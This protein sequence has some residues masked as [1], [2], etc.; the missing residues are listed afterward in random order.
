MPP[1][2]KSKPPPPRTINSSSSKKAEL[3]QLRFTGEI[4]TNELAQYK[5]A[6]DT[7][8]SKLK[9]AYAGIGQQNTALT[10]LVSQRDDLLKKLN[11]S[12]KDRNDVVAKYNDL[13][14]QIQKQQ[15]AQK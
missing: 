6:V 13:A 14:N 8:E 4:L 2:P 1:S 3:S 7:L 12:V 15:A 10:N 11:D 5:T 9:D